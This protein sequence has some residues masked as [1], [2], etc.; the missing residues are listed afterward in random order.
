MEIS[1]LKAGM[2]AMSILGSVG[3]EVWDLLDADGREVRGWGNTGCVPGRIIPFAEFAV[4]IASDGGYRSI[5]YEGLLGFNWVPG[6]LPCIPE[7]SPGLH[8]VSLEGRDLGSG[9][10]VH[11]ASRSASV[12]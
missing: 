7:R 8:L 9:I 3:S 5:M 11:L 6:S 12:Y 1:S 4:R 2:T 10:C